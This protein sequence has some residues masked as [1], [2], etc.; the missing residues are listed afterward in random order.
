MILSSWRGWAQRRETHN[1]ACIHQCCSSTA[2]NINAV[3]AAAVISDAALMQAAFCVSIASDSQHSSEIAEYGHC[4]HGL[5]SLKICFCRQTWQ[6]STSRPVCHRAH[7]VSMSRPSTGR[8]CRGEVMTCKPFSAQSKLCSAI[9]V[10][11][12][13]DST[14][15]WFASPQICC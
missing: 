14:V 12:H 4:Y 7:G 2:R 8:P 13:A 9:C 3:N 15:D 6:T 11:L 1:T 5:F 10:R